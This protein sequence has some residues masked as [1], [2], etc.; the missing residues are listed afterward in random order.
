MFQI[1]RSQ[2]IVLCGILACIPLAFVAG[3]VLHTSM[4][5]ASQSIDDPCAEDLRSTCWTQYYESFLKTNS[6][7]EALR[8]FKIKYQSVPGARTFCHPILHVIGRSAGIE[9]GSVAGAYAAG[10][11]VCRS[12]YY[13]GVLEGLFTKEGGEK[14]LDQ[15]DSICR[16]VRGDGYTYNYYSCVHG[17]GH[18]LMAFFDHDIFESLEG[19]KRL[20]GAWEQS[21]C[22]G[23]VFMENVTSDSEEMP[24]RFLKHDDPFY[25]CSAVEEKFASQCYLMQS[26]YML[27]LFNGDFVKTF[28]A[29]RGTGIYAETCFQSIGRDVSA[30]SYGD[31]D[32][33]IALCSVGGSLDERKNC[34]IGAAADYILS[35]GEAEARSLCAHGE[36][37]VREHCVERVEWHV[38]TMR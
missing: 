5:N 28:T 11:T 15:L 26:S 1:S 22:A 4:S 12:G 30:W 16:A 23:G 6:A 37:G 31:I 3:K 20:S 18:G 2:A 10:D 35:Y 7:S 19:C 9:Y 27:K 13:H 8:D 24:S 34:L 29:C 32:T 21:S 25:P 36:D 14:L 38:S 17:I 33:A